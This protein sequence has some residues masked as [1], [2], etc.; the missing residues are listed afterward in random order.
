MKK[1]L[2]RDKNGSTCYPRYMDLIAKFAKFM[3]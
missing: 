1:R 2:V 3:V